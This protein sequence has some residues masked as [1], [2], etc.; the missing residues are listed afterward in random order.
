MKIAFVFIVK[1]GEQYL[2]K[3]LNKIKKFNQDIYVVENDSIDDTRNIL[4]H[5]NLK[6]VVFLDI[7]DKHSTELC[8][9]NE[10]FNCSE[11]LKR[12]AYIRQRGLDEVMSSGIT[13]DY[14]CMMDFDFVYFDEKHLKEMFNFMDKHDDVDGIFGMSKQNW[15]GLPYDVAAIEPISKIVP[16]TLNTKRYIRVN[17][18]FSGFGIYRY[19]SVRK[20]D[21]KYDYTHTNNK[22]DHIYF[23]NHLQKLLVDTK[24]NP[25]YEVS[26]SNG[27]RNVI[28]CILFTVV[29][30]IYLLY[31]GLC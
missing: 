5:A 29:V 9:K 22:V 1:N 2:Q 21:A 27:K 17:S 15:S 25:V 12:L 3:N 31:K 8:K 13:Y 14:I 20:Y 4:L 28:L 24:F 30:I 7:D 10:E 23:N 19:S 18:A 26:S 11:R 6:K 16:I